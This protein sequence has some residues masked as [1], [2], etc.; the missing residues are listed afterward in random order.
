MF[1]NKYSINVTGITL[2]KGYSL[3]FFTLTKTLYNY[4]FW[5][6]FNISSLQLTPA[7]VYSLSFQPNWKA[8]P[9][10]TTAACI[11][12]EKTFARAANTSAPVSM[13]RW[14]ACPFAPLIFL[15]HHHPVP[16][17][18]WS[19]SPASAASAWTVTASPPSYRQC[20]DGCSRLRI[21]SLTCTPTRNPD[22]SRTP[23]SPKTPWATSS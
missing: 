9:A 16:H 13:G 4:D 8:A 2:T 12:M 6:N 5:S 15:W 22:Q 21:C 11:R 19:K 7:P 3:F 17:L 10:N 20:L 18:D 14:A 1:L 23:T